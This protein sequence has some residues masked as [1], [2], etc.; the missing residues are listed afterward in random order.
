L[1]FDIGEYGKPRLISDSLHF[2]LSHTDDHLLIAVGNVPD[3]GIDVERVNQRS[4]L[5]A[6]VQR[7]LS[8]DEL[9]QW[10]Q[11]SPDQQLDAFYRLWT[12]KEAFVKAV[13]RGIALGMELCEL[14]VEQGGQLIAI[15]SAY[16]VVSDWQ[17]TELAVPSGL[18]AALVARRCC[19]KLARKEI[20]IGA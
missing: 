5:A 8:K 3:I 18:S 4:N 15:P 9:H 14:E 7:I 12:K 1:Q 13:G 11:L 19:F 2:N 16:G 20:A 10:R 6:I 17:V